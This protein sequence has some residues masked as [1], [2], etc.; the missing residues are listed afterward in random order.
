MKQESFGRGREDMALQSMENDGKLTADNLIE[1]AK[2]PNHPS[3]H[4][5]NWDIK[6]AAYN[7]WRATARR[8][9]SRFRYTNNYKSVEISVPRYIK[10]PDLPS[11][12]QGYVSVFRVSNDRERAMSALDAEIS[13]VESS[14]KRLVALSQAF[15]LED[16]AIAVMDGI[17]IL[18]EKV[19]ELKNRPD[20]EAA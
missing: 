12:Q 5:F 15:E 14:L 6:T 10:N 19:K 4:H 3:H 11:N 2:N 17:A 20:T 7:D 18:R 9:I 13:R 1:A 8:I 16:Y